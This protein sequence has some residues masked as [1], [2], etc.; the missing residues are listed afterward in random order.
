MGG[1][2]A[3]AVGPG[4]YALN[5]P[6][7]CDNQTYVQGCTPGKASSTC[8]GVC[9]AQNACESPKPNNPDVGFICP[10]F[11]LFSDEMLQAA[12]DDWGSAN[13]PFNYAIVGHDPDMGGLDGND[14][15]TCCQCY[16]LVLDHP[17]NDNDANVNG[18]ASGP[19]AIAVPKPLIVQAFNTSAGGGKNFDVF[20]GAGGFGGNNACDPTANPKSQSGKYLYTQFPQANAPSDGNLKIVNV[21]PADCKTS[22]NLVTAATLSSSACQAAAMADCSKVASAS[23]TL[24]R[25]TIQSCIKS[26]APDSYYHLNW[27]EYAKRVECP[28]HLTEVTGCK[29][30][31]QGLPQADPNVTTAAQAA[32]DSSFHSGYTT[33]TMQDCCKPTCA[34]QDYVTGSQGHE[35][36]VGQYNS[37]YSCDQN[38]APVTE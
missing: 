15:T 17:G 6:K 20:M 10:R 21:D 18:N 29:L 22:V 16:Q 7:Q 37:F 31:P 5:P 30:A 4:S 24:T 11:I 26:N 13:P 14:T 3:G 38:G 28:T 2:E 33:T 9:S 27:A 36:A 1:D 25:E 35:T 8:G 34:W 19:S 23:A 32:A 12:Q